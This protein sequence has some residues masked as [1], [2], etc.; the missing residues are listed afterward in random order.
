HLLSEK[1]ERRIEGRNAGHHPVW[2]ASGEAQ[3]PR[4]RRRAIYRDGFAAKAEELR[5]TRSDERDGALHLEGCGLSRLS[6]ITYQKIE[7]RFAVLL[8]GIRGTDEPPDALGRRSAPIG[9]VG[10]TGVANRF[11]DDCP[12]ALGKA[13]VLPQ[14]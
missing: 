2:H 11:V 9:G 14:V 3:P 8:Q 4:A 13:R 1:V 7:E 10:G 12:R 5:G 6:N